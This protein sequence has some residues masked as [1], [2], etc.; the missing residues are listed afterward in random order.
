MYICKEASE[1]YLIALCKYFHCD[2]TLLST[3][4]ER[5]SARFSV[6]DRISWDEGI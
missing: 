1:V 4:C 2:I 3:R 5:F 6:D